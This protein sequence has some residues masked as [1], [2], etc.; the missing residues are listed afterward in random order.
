ME[1]FSPDDWL[2]VNEAEVKAKISDRTF[3][4]WQRDHLFINF[5]QTAE[6]GGRH[7]VNTSDFENFMT[8]KGVREQYIYPPDLAKVL[9]RLADYLSPDKKP[10]TLSSPLTIDAELRTKMLTLTQEISTKVEEAFVRT[11]NQALS[12]QREE[13]TQ[14]LL[15]LEPLLTKQLEYKEGE[16]QGRDELKKGFAK[17]L[18]KASLINVCLVILVIGLSSGLFIW[19]NRKTR[20]DREVRWCQIR[21]QTILL[22][23]LLT[24]TRLLIL[25]ILQNLKKKKPLSL[26]KA[27]ILISK[28]NF[29]SII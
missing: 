14:Y 21:T 7:Y 15:R 1:N 8:K 26:M 27:K 22:T 29:V 6:A 4:R 28:I 3:Y 18:T 2:T 25:L 23:I 19:Q 9:D 16:E 20:L 12:K 13:F 17:T 5:T 24:I 10:L 11:M